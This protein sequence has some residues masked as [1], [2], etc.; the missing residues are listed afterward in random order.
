MDMFIYNFGVGGVRT[1]TPRTFY[2]AI[3]QATLL[4]GSK[5]WVTTPRIGTTLSRFYHRVALR[6][7]VIQTNRDML[8][9]WEYKP[10]Y[11]EMAAVGIEEAE[12]YILRCQNTIAQ[13]IAIC[14]ILET[15]LTT[16]HR[17][18]AWMSRL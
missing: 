10:L 12:K 6:M 13:Y 11:T 16:E 2:K 9:Q 15:F 1:R 7:E 14:P 4:F 8:G 17:S 5:T 18:G 3:V